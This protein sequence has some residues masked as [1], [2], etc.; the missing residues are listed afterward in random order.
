MKISKLVILVAL[1]LTACG[2]KADKK[3]GGG[4]AAAG[5]PP[6]SEAAA[7]YVA[8]HAA[9]G[10]NKIAGLKPTPD[11]A[12]ILASKLEADC[13]A[14]NWSADAKTCIIAT[15]GMDTL[16]TEC[17][18]KGEGEM[19]VLQIVHDATNELKAARPAG[20]DPAAP[21]PGA[22]DGSAP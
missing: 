9:A 16:T 2:K 15:K 6:C 4:G 8:N 22:A 20:G 11:E 19:E 21:A 12:K 5:G 17:F 1:A 7:A 18:K 3:G 14:R 10:G 13:T